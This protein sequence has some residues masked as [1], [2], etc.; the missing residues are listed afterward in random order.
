MGYAGTYWSDTQARKGPDF[1]TVLT[2]DTFAALR[3][4]PFVED[5]QPA[6]TLGK[7]A[8]GD[9]L[10]ARW[11]Y[12]ASSLAADDDDTAIKPAFLAAGDLGR[13]IKAEGFGS[14]VS[15]GQVTSLIGGDLTALDAIETA[16]VNA[17]ARIMFL[18]TDSSAD[19]QYVLINNPGPEV[20]PWM[21]RP[22]DY[23]AAQNDKGWKLVSVFKDG[24]VCAWDANYPGQ[25]RFRQI[26]SR[27][28]SDGDA[29]L[30]VDENQPFTIES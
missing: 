14:S 27:T 3:A 30:H 11:H 17:G 4:I 23:D 13:W 24:V 16:E 28:D 6:E 5:R 2:V 15:A 20:V 19:L 18:H 12:D 22:D 29:T 1:R 21:I 10:P 8:R 7:S 9:S 25:N 26:F